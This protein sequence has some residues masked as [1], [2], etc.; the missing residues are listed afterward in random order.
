MA[1]VNDSLGAIQG[2]LTPYDELAIFT[3]NN[4]PRSAP[5][6]PA[7]KVPVCLRYWPSPR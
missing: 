6:L 7:P 5:A 3:Y 2:A 4:G 1:K